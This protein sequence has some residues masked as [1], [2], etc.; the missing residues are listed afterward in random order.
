M[1]TT[2]NDWFNGKRVLVLGGLGFIG[3]NLA[4][5]CRELGATVTVLDSLMDHGGGNAANLD[6]HRDGIKVII[7]DLRDHELV[8]PVIAGQD[9]VFHC[10]GHTSHTYS[11]RN[12]YLDIDI[13]CKGTINVL[14]SVRRENAEARVVYVGTSTQCGAMVHRP[15][16]ELHPEFP[17]DIY[18][19]NKS[20]A[21]K[22][23]LIYHQVY[24]LKT[25]VVRL[26]NVF[27]PRANIKSSHAGVL[28]FFIGL[29]LQ[30][31]DLTIFGGGAQKRNV[32]YVN[33]GVDALLAAAQSEQGYGEVFFASSDEEHAISDFADMV[34]GA[35]GAGRV[36]H[37]EWPKEWTNL[38]V[39]D[40]AISNAKM[41]EAT[42]WQPRSTVRDGLAKTVEFFKLRLD[43]YLP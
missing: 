39:G 23:H 38:D 31:K 8:Q 1:S 2:A 16:D 18:S 29:A 40:V 32:L 9:V 25:T 17:R 14:E 19:A 30:D 37:V 12:P 33:D 42:G 36:A 35:V 27:G 21:E 13:N 4:I 34:V 41:K 6:D 24:G 43:S 10:A 5:R 3:S 22:Y 11:N 7:N 15:M 20:V 28:N 26:A